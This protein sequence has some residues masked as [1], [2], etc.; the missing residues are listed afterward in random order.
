MTLRLEFFGG[1]TVTDR[2][3]DRCN[4]RAAR[5]RALLAYLALA[6]RGAF[7]RSHVA[8]LLWPDV[9]EEEAR[10][11]LRQCLSL[12]RQA[13]GAEADA[14]TFDRDRVGLKPGAFESDV[15]CF[16]RLAAS[17]QPEDWTRA[18]IL[19]AGELLAGI[20]LAGTPFDEWLAA[21]REDVNQEAISVLARV[22]RTQSASGDLGA[23]VATVRRIIQR[24]PFDEVERRHLMRLFVEAG[25]STSA[26]REYR[27]YCTLLRDQLSIE[28]SEETMLLYR[29]ILETHVRSSP[30][31]AEMLAT[32]A[33][34]L[35]QL[36][37]C[38]IV[39]DLETRIVGFNASAEQSFGLRKA[40]VIG[41][42]P[43]VLHADDDDSAIP[44]TFTHLALTHGRW[45]ET[46][47]LTTRDG[48]I[49]PM[50]R[51]VVTLRSPSGRAIG[52]FGMSG[53]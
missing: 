49:R 1:L 21:Q 19:C 41:K 45:T 33:S 35:E 53:A 26:I 29:S 11:S 52:A 5:A 38:V 16:R 25:R 18:S 22:A 50:R 46:V 15:A 28:P 48:A 12:T 24:D 20:D 14:L 3:G 27:D 47:R 32:Y 8:G 51:S 34:V 10:H 9:S 23:A 39:T 44:L 43:A 40:D 37:D 6:P 31:D 36:P 4:V 42:T 7:A 30:D 17:S 13:L 2:N